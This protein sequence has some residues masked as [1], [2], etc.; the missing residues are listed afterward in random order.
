MV[1]IVSR[2]QLHHS[3][4]TRA[5]ENKFPQACRFIMPNVLKHVIKQFLTQKFFVICLLL[6]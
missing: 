6:H 2:Y 5:R 3:I 4:H 1:S